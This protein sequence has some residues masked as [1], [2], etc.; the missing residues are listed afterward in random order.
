M[1]IEWFWRHRNR[2]GG[3]LRHGR[4]FREFQ[5]FHLRNHRF[6]RRDLVRRR[7]RD[8]PQPFD[9][10]LQFL[11]RH[12]DCPFRIELPQGF[13]EFDAVG[14]GRCHGG[15]DFLARELGHLGHFGID[16]RR[17]VFELTRDP[18]ELLGHGVDRCGG[19]LEC[20]VDGLSRAVR[21][22]RSLLGLLLNGQDRCKVGNRPG[23]RIERLD[24]KHEVFDVL[25]LCGE[26]ARAAPPHDR[27]L[28]VVHV[29]P[30]RVEIQ[31]HLVKL[32]GFVPEI[33]QLF[34]EQ[35][36]LHAGQPGFVVR[37]CRVHILQKNRL[38]PTEVAVKPLVGGG[39]V[40]VRP[41]KVK[42]QPRPTRD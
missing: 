3:R 19:L 6:N 40:G 13:D 1:D 5:G 15:R 38:V 33:G 2:L 14:L 28:L 17:D 11:D 18:V 27:H 29:D 25:E 42:R 8:G 7:T 24:K 30:E 26:H 10:C 37:L 20:L 9:G 4:S 16:L 12:S 41:V 23:W 32:D 35:P 34:Q 22:G 21:R 36:R 39:G 31:R